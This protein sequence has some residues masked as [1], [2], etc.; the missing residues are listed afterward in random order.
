LSF[1]PGV[2]SN[3][4]GA[5]GKSVDL[6]ATPANHDFLNNTDH[7]TNLYVVEVGG[8]APPPPPFT[9]NRTKNQTLLSLG[10]STNVSTTAA[11]SPGDSSHQDIAPITGLLAFSDKDIGD[12]LTASAGAATIL[13]NGK[14]LTSELSAADALALTSALDH[15]SFGPG[16]I[17]NG[18]GSP[19]T[20]PSCG[21]P[22]AHPAHLS[23]T[24]HLS[25]SYA[26]QV[27][28]STPQN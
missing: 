21:P 14:L 16:V 1:G 3:G 20:I 10:N 4:G 18:G 26:V 22:R 13:L 6:G 5:Q 19:A 24:P 23:H 15:L 12:S 8:S 25:I 27:G 9:T 11:E 2:I 7:L 28:D 17:S